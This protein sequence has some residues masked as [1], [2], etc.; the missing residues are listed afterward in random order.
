MLMLSWILASAVAS[1]NIQQ[2]ETELEI[3]K[4]QVAVHLR[5]PHSAVFTNV[6]FLTP[7]LVC[8]SVNAKNGFGGYIGFV[9]FAAYT[10]PSVS[11]L[12]PIVASQYDGVY[13]VVIGYD[14]RTR[15]AVRE[16]CRTD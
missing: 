2:D 14:E 16:L 13:E 9:E 11:N 7:K 4:I 15:R 6:R 12:E 10:V 1:A 5:D 8:G 3:A